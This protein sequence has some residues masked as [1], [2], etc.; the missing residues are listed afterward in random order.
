MRWAAPI[1]VIASAFILSPQIAAQ[2][3]TPQSVDEVKVPISD[4]RHIGSATVRAAA[5]Q[6]TKD[7]PTIALFGMEAERWP[8][9]RLAIQ[10]AAYEGYKVDG[11]H[12]G[13]T[14][15]PPSLEIYAKGLHVTRPINPNSISASVLTQLI[16]DVVKEFY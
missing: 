1:A 15:A 5:T 11:I 7:A 8:V 16:R 6:F 14:D 13:S 3:K 12:I 10:Q 4:V 2:S 9:I